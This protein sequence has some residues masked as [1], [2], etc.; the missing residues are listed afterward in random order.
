M[1]RLIYKIVYTILFIIS[2]MP[3]WVLYI[4]A[5]ILFFFAYYVIGYRKKVVLENLRLAFPEKT[6]KQRK[7]IAREFM[8]HLCDLVAEN[9]KTLTISKAELQK[10]FKAENI[11]LLNSFYK[12]DKSV[13]LMTGHYG[14]WEWGSI[15]NTLTEFQSL[16]VYKPLRNPHFNTLIKDIRERFKS[17]LISNRYIVPALFRKSKENIN[18]ATYILSDQSPKLNAYKHVD[19][20]MGIR[21]PVFTGTEEIA[22]R[23]DLAVLYLKIEKVKRGYYKA[24]FV[25]LADEPKEVP[26]FDI[27]RRFFD[28]IEKQIKEKPAYYLW[29]HKRW[30]HRNKV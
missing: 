3:M 16:A 24:T 12:K 8:K 25:I 27:T 10:R 4:M 11:E 21:V 18:T 30:K 28:E 22:K 1:Q 19:T 15:L 7:R 20:F 17:Q 29:S 6:E 14:N 23:L 9:I 5:D 2:K 13:L 26:D